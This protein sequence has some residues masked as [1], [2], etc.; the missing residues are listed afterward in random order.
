[1]GRL[2]RQSERAFRGFAHARTD[3]RGQARRKRLRLPANRVQKL[4][5][6]IPSR[7][8]THDKGC[9]P[10]LHFFGGERRGKDFN[11]YI[12]WHNRE[13]GVGRRAVKRP[14]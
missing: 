7:V 14:G 3:R 6:D 2:H 1:M 8:V 11:R 9:Q 4:D 10:F 5:A 12:G 13:I